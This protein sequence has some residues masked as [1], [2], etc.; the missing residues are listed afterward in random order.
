MSEQSKA[1]VLADLFEKVVFLTDVPAYIQ[2]HHADAA[3]QLR[4]LEAENAALRA[5]LAQG[6]PALPVDEREAM[7]S[8]LALLVPSVNRQSFVVNGGSPLVADGDTEFYSAKK[9]DAITKNIGAIARS[10][11]ET[12][13]RA[14]LKPALPV[15]ERELPP[16]PDET[17]FY[18]SDDSC[19]TGYTADQ[20]R[21]YAQK[22]RAAPQQAVPEGY[23]L[24]ETFAIEKAATLLRQHGFSLAATRLLS[25]A[26]E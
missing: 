4:K 10:A 9:I 21:E 19:I 12:Q 11:L 6:E 24:V 13:A 14:A 2:K 7:Q 23:Q 15:G 3:K 20:M 8:I 16:L 17:Y 18:E 1:L 5:Q 26:K 22:V 25:A